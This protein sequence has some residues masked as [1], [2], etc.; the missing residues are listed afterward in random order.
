MK[1]TEKIVGALAAVVALIYSFAMPVYAGPIELQPCSMQE[2]A[3]YGANYVL[4]LRWDAAALDAYSTSNQIFA[5][6]NAVPA[7]SAVRVKLAKLDQAWDGANTE[8]LFICVGTPATSNLFLN[9][10]QQ[11]ADGTEVFH[12]FPD[13][14]LE[15]GNYISGVTNVI[16][17]ITNRAQFQYFATATNVITALY[18]NSLSA[19]SAWTAGRTRVYFEIYS[20]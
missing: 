1:R 9:A 18:P 11:A 5:T 14:Y 17:N 13:L 8:S 2:K 7:G 4:D 10:T 6:T 16:T 15:Q 3:A 19:I 20:P 12:A